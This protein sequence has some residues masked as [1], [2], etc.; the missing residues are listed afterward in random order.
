MKTT[1]IAFLVLALAAGSASAED[2]KDKA[3]P[4]SDKNVFQ[5]TESSIGDWANRNKIWITRKK[6]GEK[7]KKD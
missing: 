2:R 1:W 5:K 4:K 6:K 7:D 3:K